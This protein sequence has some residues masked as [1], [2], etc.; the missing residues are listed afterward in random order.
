MKQPHSIF[1]LLP[2][3]VFILA[4][5]SFLAWNPPVQAEM[6][7]SFEASSQFP[8]PGWTKTNLLGGSGWYRLPVGVLPLPGWGNGTSSVPP[9]AGAGSYNAYCSWYTGGSASQGYHNDQWVITPQ[10]FGL[11]A[12]ST[13]SYWLR[14]SFT[15]Y[16]DM[17]YVRISTGTANPADFTRVIYT[18]SWPQGGSQF[19]PW[20]NTV[21]NIGSLGIPPGT[22][23]YVAFQEYVW[24]NTWNG[25]AVEL[26]VI[27]SDLTPKPS[28]TVTPTQ[29][30]FTAEYVSNPVPNRQ[31]FVL[32]NVGCTSLN[33]SNR[34][35]F[36][37]VGGWATAGFSNGVLNVGDVRYI[38]VTVTSDL[39]TIDTHYATNWFYVNGATNPITRLPVVLNVTRWH[40]SI[41]F[42]VIPDQVYTNKIALS[43]TASSDLMVTFGM[44]I[45][46]GKMSGN[47]LSFTSTG[48][49]SVLAM[50]PG[51][52]WWDAAPMKTNTFMVTRANVPMT[53]GNL[54]ATYDGSPHPV[55]VT[56]TPTGVPVTIAYSSHATPVNA[57]TYLVTGRVDEA[58]LMGFQVATQVIARAGQTII[59]PPISDKITTGLVG[60]AATASTGLAVTFATNG[61][62][63]LI[64]GGTNLS[65]YGP[66]QIQILAIQSGTANYDTACA[67][68]SFT[69]SKAEASVVLGDLNQTYNGFPRPAS[70]TTEPPGLTVQL[71]YNGGTTTPVGAG[72]YAV[73]GAIQEAMYQ[74]FQTGTL[75][76]SKAD[77]QLLYSGLSQ[78][79]VYSKIGLTNLSVQGQ[80]VTYQC[81]SGPALITESTNLSFAEVGLAAVRAS[82][83]GDDNYNPTWTDIVT[84]VYLVTPESGPL[85]GGNIVVLT[86]GYIGVDEH[87]ITNV[88]IGNVHAEILRQGYNW[89]EVRAG[90][91]SPGLA[92]IAIQSTGWAGT[93]FTN[94]YRY[95]VPGV[96]DRVVPNLGS[97][98]GGYP[99]AL[100]GSNLCDGTDA[101]NVTLCGVPASVLSQSATQIVVTAGLAGVG[102]LGLGDARAY[103]V[104]F[105]ETVATNAYTY[106]APGLQ[107]LGTNGAVVAS[108]ESVSRPKGTDF[109]PLLTGAS[110]VHTFSIT[111][112][113]TDVLNISG[114]TTG[115]VSS[116]KFQVSSLGG[117]VAVGGVSLFTVTFNPEAAGVFTA[118]LNIQN[119]SPASTCALNLSGLGCQ[120]T[121]NL[122]PYGGG[123]S[124]TITNG[125]LG[126]GDIT[127]VLVGGVAAT[128]TGQGLNWIMITLPGF[129]SQGLKDIVL[130]SVSQ[131]D[132]LLAGAYTVNPAGWIGGLTWGPYAWTNMGSGM[133][134]NVNALAIGPNGEVYAGGAF[135]N[136]GGVE[137]RAIAKWDGSSWT[138]LDIG[139]NGAV[140][141]LAVGLDGEVYAGG[142]FTNLTGGCEA[143]N[144]AK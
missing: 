3:F 14:F 86:N 49:V 63:A 85:M 93:T 20:N 112:N 79:P 88:T 69:V 143:R 127:N 73:T 83:A 125:A 8:P 91:G 90:A 53:F 110:A 41:N 132:I 118:Q 36:G 17:F 64:T 44:G 123:N 78:L 33:L 97:Y 81:V 39:Q 115:G 30:V 6:F 26:D 38:S 22:P 96:I 46:P 80:P 70:A 84:H 31:D 133:S 66:G 75:V 87:D 1:R 62:P 34:L 51:D 58:Y 120:L 13:L 114:W 43:A 68:N 57:G 99:V 104:S 144:I 138:N 54:T 27:R 98:T 139:L 94:V 71:T 52:Y 117:S 116:S 56:T 11:T 19:G 29:L 28:Y 32:R 95:N 142:S 77:Q 35:T 100:I 24:D 136:A 74:G 121:T 12:T 15:N 37:G 25:A 107:I 61:G 131:G 111:N 7:E 40:Q 76:V 113:G 21:I 119:D 60:L 89:V 105:G 4:F 128:I 50:Q 10:L 45:G 101:T 108:G 67:T 2:G 137:A 47:V 42:P 65:F 72:S 92:H 23:I 141:A 48:R 102:N 59:F 18:N 140:L 109:G 5:G 124:L 122:G 134:T 135:T 129:T 106:L 9:T 126:V 82:Q 130:Q 16:P 55:T 103:S